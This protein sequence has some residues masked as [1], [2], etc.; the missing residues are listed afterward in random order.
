MPE[1][2][3]KLPIVRMYRTAISRVLC[4]VLGLFWVAV[5]GLKLAEI[6]TGTP[7][8]AAVP[9]W[10]SRFPTWVVL[11]AIIAESAIGMLIWTGASVLGLAGGF[12]ALVSFS[13]LIF[14]MPMLPGQACGCGVPVFPDTE[15]VVLARNG[16]LMACHALALVCTVKIN[17]TVPLGPDQY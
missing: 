11:G 9:D 14:F 3:P 2:I 5:A 1:A 16:L 15:G 6:L 10:S 7:G 8:T 17:S 4:L 13:T 12:L